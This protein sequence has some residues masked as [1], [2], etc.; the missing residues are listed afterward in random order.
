M[1]VVGKIIT[2][3]LR[4]SQGSAS[5]EPYSTVSYTLFYWVEEI[6]LAPTVHRSS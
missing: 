3:C 1:F 2:M 4:F 5:E 6:S